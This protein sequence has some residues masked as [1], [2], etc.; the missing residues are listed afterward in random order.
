MWQ[1][2]L[3]IESNC[4]FCPWS[5]YGFR[6]F[7]VTRPLSLFYLHNLNFQFSGCGIFI[8]I[9]WILAHGPIP[10][11]STLAK[12]RLYS[13][14]LELAV[15]IHGY[16]TAGG[17]WGLAIEFVSY[18]EY[19]DTF[20]VHCFAKWYFWSAVR[21]LYLDS[22]WL[23]PIQFVWNCLLSYHKN[24]LYLQE[25]NGVWLCLAWGVS[26]RNLC[27]IRKHIH[28]GLDSITPHSHPFPNHISSLI[29]IGREIIRQG[30]HMCITICRFS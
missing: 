30:S 14:K 22:G 18:T 7:H 3:L 23:Q 17:G 8:V 21:P 2:L 12:S 9:V 11:S 10:N 28:Q 19:S 4:S 26:N 25:L 6:R 5:G 20:A 1:K 16:Y 24:L 13:S 29:F 27:G 15:R